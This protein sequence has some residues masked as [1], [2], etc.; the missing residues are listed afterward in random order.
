MDSSDRLLLLATQVKS[1]TATPQSNQR[2]RAESMKPKLLPKEWTDY[3]GLTRRN[4]RPYTALP[5]VSKQIREEFTQMMCLRATFE[6]TLDENAAR[7]AEELAEKEV[8]LN[9]VSKWR[10]EQLEREELGET[11][12][13]SI[14]IRK[15]TDTAFWNIAPEVLSRMRTCRLRIKANPALVRPPTPT[16]NIPRGGENQPLNRNR[17]IP[18][19][20]VITPGR[21]DPAAHAASAPTWQFLHRTLKT[22]EAMPRLTELTVTIEASTGDQLWNPISLWHHTSQAFK[23][24]KVTAFK[25]MSFG[26]EDWGLG[27]EP[28]HLERHVVGEDDEEVVGEMGEDG[29]GW[30]WRCSKG[31]FLRYDVAEE[32]PIRTFCQVVFRCKQCDG[33]SDSE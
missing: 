31:H 23:Q 1:P 2:A 20:V 4:W 5:L 25:R 24:S 32:M 16:G 7:D 9:T 13:S 18:N 10:A 33:D 22:I 19:P 29:S 26:L 12:N 21:F 3:I 8:E 11:A 14:S 27:N 6:F 15:A 17:G 30:Q 28:N